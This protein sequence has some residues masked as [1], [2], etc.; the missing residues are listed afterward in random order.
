MVLGHENEL[1]RI[2]NVGCNIGR[3]VEEL[4][5]VATSDDDLVC[6]GLLVPVSIVVA[7]TSVTART[8]GRISSPRR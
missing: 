8:G 2:A 1:D 7:L 5:G 3:A 6:L 4:W